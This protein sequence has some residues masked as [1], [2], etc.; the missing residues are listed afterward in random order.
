MRLFNPPP[1]EGKTH[2]IGSTAGLI[3]KHPGIEYDPGK[4]T[5]VTEGI[6]D[7]LSLI[8]LGYQA[9]AIISAGQDPTNVDLSEFGELVFAFDYDEAGKKALKKRTALYTDVKRACPLRGDWNDL[10][11]SLPKENAKKFF[12]DRRAEFEAKAEMALAE[13][14]YDYATIF[15]EFYGRAAGLFDFERCLYFS[16]YKATQNGPVLKTERVSNFTLE[17]RHYQ[18]ETSNIE[19]PMNRFFLDIFPRRGQP[20]ACSVTAQEL[21]S[22]HGL[23]TMFLQRARAL[24]EG[25]RP[26]SLALARRIVEAGAPVVR[27]LQIIGY[28]RE[29]DCYVFKHFLINR[30]GGLVTP[31]NHGFFDVSRS[32]SIRPAPHPT[33]N[34]SKGLTSAE[35]WRL[36]HQAWGDKGVTALAWE[37]AGWWVNQIKERI[38]FFPFLSFCGDPQTGKTRLTRI[39]NAIQA[40]SEE[41]LPMTRVN[42]Q[43]GEIRKL[44]QR[45]GLFK[46]LLE[47]NNAE[48]ARFDIDSILTLYNENPI[49]TTALKTIDIQTRDVPFLTSI[50]FVQNKE[51]FKTKA[52]KECIISIHFKNEDVTDETRA[53]FNK[54]LQI[55]LPNLALLFVD[56]MSHR[57]QI[58]ADWYNEFER[59]RKELYE[60]IP[61]NRLNENHALILSFHRLLCKLIFLEY[62]L[63][64]YIE[65]IGQKRFDECNRN[66][67]SVADHL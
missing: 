59:A 7:A 3:W 37:V 13:T 40:L 2:N 20:V 12:Q 62:D 27:Q 55:P 8:E 41:G 11:T 48:K 32:L 19:E 24:W 51:P 10:L 35:I 58:E 4:E 28:E 44:A 6:I 17:V 63:K 5:F 15:E 26:A 30:K 45:S 61:D 53:A 66:C 49:Q 14:A 25:E 36:I 46:A 67:E 43:K 21:A 60:T 56:V 23:T 18:L 22:P 47:A 39:L 29:S 9:I 52:Q 31:N 38:G 42:T 34:P 64:P 57:K 33:L 54:L 50:M 16:Y 65:E 1:G